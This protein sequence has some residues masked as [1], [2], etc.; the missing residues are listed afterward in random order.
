MTKIYNQTKIKHQ[1]KFLRKSATIHEIILWSRIKNNQLG[2]KFR[3]QYSIG[4]YIADFCCLEKRLIVEI[5]GSEHFES[6]HDFIRDK[7]VENLGFRILRIWNNEI[8]NNLNGVIEKILELLNDPSAAT[9]VATA[10]L[11]SARGGREGERVK[12][13]NLK[14]ISISSSP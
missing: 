5:D 2:Y 11:V 3:R 6:I 14:K 4:K 1:R 12:E 9:K 7:Y 13:N 8:N 10:P